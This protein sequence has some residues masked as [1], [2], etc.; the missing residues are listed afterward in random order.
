MDVGVGVHGKG[1]EVREGRQPLPNNVHGRHV[2]RRELEAKTDLEIR[3]NEIMRGKQEGG[4]MSV[5][6]RD[7]VQTRISTGR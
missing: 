7:S 2:P 3:E 4:C 5:A 1:R 6:G